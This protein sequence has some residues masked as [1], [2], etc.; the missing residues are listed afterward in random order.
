MIAATGSRPD[1]PLE[2]QMGDNPPFIVDRYRVYFHYDGSHRVD[3]HYLFE[4]QAHDISSETHTWSSGT[5]G[6]PRLHV[7]DMLRSKDV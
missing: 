1:T 7:R 4:D 3:V 5:D 2:L 6:M